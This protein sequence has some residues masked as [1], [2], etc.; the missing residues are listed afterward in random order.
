MQA[1]VVRAPMEFDV[2]DSP[3]PVVPESGEWLIAQG[4]P[5]PF[6]WTVR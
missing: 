3:V 1:V 6:W 5:D 2:E 4:E